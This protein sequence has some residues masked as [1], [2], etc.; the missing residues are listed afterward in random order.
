MFCPNCG[1]KLPDG[2]KFCSACGEMISPQPPVQ[3]T[4]GDYSTVTDPNVYTGGTNNKPPKAKKKLKPILTAVIAVV[5]V[6]AIVTGGI[7]GFKAIFSKN[8]DPIV[9]VSNDKFRL[10]KDIESDELIA[11]DNAGDSSNRYYT[12]SPD[13][14][15]FYYSIENGSS[16]DT[17]TLKRVEWDKLKDGSDKND[18]Y[19]TTVTK[20]MGIGA[21]GG[22][23]LYVT[24][25]ND[26]KVLYFDSDDTFWLFDEE[27]SN[28]KIAS[29]AQYFF[30]DMNGNVVY[31]TDYDDETDIEKLYYVNLADVDNPVL[32]DKNCAGVCSSIYDDDEN[33]TD[34][35]YGTKTK[36]DDDN[37]THTLYKYSI[38][39]DAPELITE[40]FSK[41]VDIKDDEFYFLRYTEKTVSPYDL[42]NDSYAKADAGLKE[43][44]Y[45]DYEV[46]YY[47]YEM[48]RY[49][50]TSEYEGLY[51]TCTKNVYLLGDYWCES[52]E[53]ALENWSFED[54]GKLESA[55][56][57]FYDKYASKEDEDGYITVTSDVKSALKKI[58]KAYGYDED[59][60]IYMCYGKY[61]SGTKT[62]WDAYD[63]AYDKWS[64]AADRIELREELKSDENL[65]KLEE[66]CK[67]KDGEVTVV[68]SDILARSIDDTHCNVAYTTL[69]LI[70]EKIK[71]EDIEDISNVWASVKPVRVKGSFLYCID[72]GET[73]KM[74]EESEGVYLD[75]DGYSFPDTIYEG[76]KLYM[77]NNDDFIAVAD[78][79]DGT[80][81]TFSKI[82]EKGGLIGVYDSKFYYADKSGSSD[83]SYNVCVYD[84]E[85][86]ER[87]E[88]NVMIT[89]LYEDGSLMFYANTD[90]DDYDDSESY[91]G[92]ASYIDPDGNKT[93]L[94]DKISAAV[95][96][97][98]GNV[99]YINDGTLYRFDGEEKISIAR[100]AEYF[101][102]R[103][104]ANTKY[105][106]YYYY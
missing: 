59:Y 64:D 5:L 26:G 91:K 25:L 67:V 82:C 98:G 77:S 105:T 103:N 60:W 1:A 51:A 69:D 12:F 56:Q 70:T 46:P 18:D 27:E 45:D 29:N 30:C 2:S 71:I 14:K 28:I 39:A 4:P 24:A 80:V 62:D 40:N 44:N 3:P 52:V 22:Y 35:Y 11:F 90:Y 49:D 7:F 34:I 16:S 88:E 66:L 41:L 96:V 84:G 6:G 37:S 50:D 92:A 57:D 76:G 42:V 94:G 74:S 93:N 97:D 17:Y 86:S 72:A 13:G 47:V 23:L 36:T 68:V 104:Y 58:A 95:K 21:W 101:V 10:L 75:D 63:D 78:V 55:L 43:P 54:R 38:G 83:R 61:Q 48:V 89:Y 33:L 100:N 8:D 20:N 79:T 106:Y 85:S 102:V 15:Y 31:A 65:I 9:V 87:L 73:L 99:L 53:Y 32:I 81:G 19:I